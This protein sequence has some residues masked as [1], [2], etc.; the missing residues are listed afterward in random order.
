M[1]DGDVLFNASKKVFDSF[2]RSRVIRLMNAGG[3]EIINIL[4]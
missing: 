2:P 4:D 3:S 1:E